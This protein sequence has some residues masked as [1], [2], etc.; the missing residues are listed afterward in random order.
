MWTPRILHSLLYFYR[1]RYNLNAL[2]SDIAWF[3]LGPCMFFFNKITYQGLLPTQRWFFPFFCVR[4]LPQS[5]TA[6]M[7]Q[8]SGNLVTFL[9][10]RSDLFTKA[11]NI[12]WWMLDESE[13]LNYGYWLKSY[14]SA[15]LW[16]W[17]Q[18]TYR[19]FL[20]RNQSCYSARV[21]TASHWSPLWL[22]SIK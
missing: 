13:T 16:L 10:D 5:A 18:S 4:I 19:G 7:D 8:F 20:H 17:S 22:S 3:I 6:I 15:S 14:W 9:R 12:F 1:S 21:Y 2:A 11:H